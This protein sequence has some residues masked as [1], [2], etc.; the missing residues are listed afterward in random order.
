MRSPQAMSS[1]AL[2]A[3]WAA[4]QGIVVASSPELAV[5]PDVVAEFDRAVEIA[6]Q[7]L[8]RV[9]QITRCR[10]LPAEWTPEGGEM[11]ASVKIMRRAVHEKYGEVFDALYA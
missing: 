9:E 11:T 5:H 1:R 6:N 10:V 8:A 7:D 3:A 2:T 4:S